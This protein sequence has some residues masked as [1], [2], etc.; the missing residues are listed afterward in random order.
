MAREV[1]KREGGPAPE[2]GGGWFRCYVLGFG[3]GSAATLYGVLALLMGRTFLPGYHAAALLVKGG[4]ALALA[5]AYLTGG[6]YL[7]LR[8][9]VERKAPAF[10]ARSQVHLAQNALLGVF[11][12]ALAYTLWRVGSLAS[13][14]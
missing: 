9:F 2:R 3:L 13:A 14:V 12:A 5:L 8:L 6:V 1:S 10:T 4:S 7:L 11:I